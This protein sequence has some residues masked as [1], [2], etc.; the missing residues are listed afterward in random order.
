MN[1]I[2]T[3]SLEVGNSI[4]EKN[5]AG[6]A[7]V[8]KNNPISNYFHAI[9]R[10][11]IE[12]YFLKNKNI[13]ISNI[14]FTTTANRVEIQFF[15]YMNFRPTFFPWKKSAAMHSDLEHKNKWNST[16]SRTYK[17]REMLSFVSNLENLYQK[18]V[19]LHINRVHYPYVNAQILSQ[20]LCNNAN[21]NNFIEFTESIFLYPR[22]NAFLLPYYIVGI[23]LTLHGR[24]ITERQIPRKTTNIKVQGTLS[25]VK[26]KITKDVGTTTIKNELGQF[27]L[28]VE[29]AQRLGK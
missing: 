13:L 10:K 11:I 7:S 27:T 18:E 25:S 3:N 2:L 17:S 5:S 4:I 14:Q 28:R 16:T 15:Y 21:S 9:A 19:K 12:G 1:T 8:N 29:I 26:S 6:T 22:I 20:Y 23:K 24:L